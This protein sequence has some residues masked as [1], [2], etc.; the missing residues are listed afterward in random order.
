MSRIR[1]L[2]VIVVASSAC[3]VSTQAQSVTPDETKVSSGSDQDPAQIFARG[4]RALTDGNLREAELDFKRVLAL[5][6][7]AA[8]AYVNLGVIQM[9]HKQWD[10][11]LSSLHSA[12]K[13]APELA[14]IRLNIGLAN[15]RKGDYRHAIPAFESVV[16][17]APDSVQARYLLGQCYFFTDR[18]VEA[19]DVLEP[20]W[21]KQST[22]LNYLYVLSTAADKAERKDLGDRAI[23]R[24]AEVGGDTA[25]VHML[26]GKAMLNL[27]AYD[28]A[29]RELAAAQQADPKLPFVHFNLGLLYSKKGDY[30]RA[31]SEFL[32][33]I[34]LE[35]DLP[36]NYEELGNVYALLNENIEAEKNYQHALRLDA[37]MLNSHLGLAKIHQ[38][39]G[40]YAKALANLDAAARLDPES[41]RIHYLRGQVLVRMGKKIEAKKEIEMSVHMSSARRDKRQRE[42]EAEPIPSPELTHDHQ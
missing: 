9:R 19:V 8:A 40:H 4:E 10:A 38:T 7:R 18:Y 22:D 5:D 29:A 24:M 31:K 25:V 41:S 15:Y 30:A 36:F 26:I 33:D 21:P 6:P 11:A 37:R 32:K 35:P 39:Q 16:K 27:E 12:Q 3:T 14:G 1:T 34:A 23:A 20:I 28:D 2:L 42:L 17:D 13:L